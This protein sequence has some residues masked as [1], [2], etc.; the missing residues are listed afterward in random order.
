MPN[1][2]L[3]GL[4]TL[5]AVLINLSLG[6]YI[7][8][9]N[10]RDRLNQSYVFVAAALCIWGFGELV[11]RTTSN[12]GIALQA[13]KF[14]S[15]GYIFLP[16]VF[17]DFVLVLI[18]RK[19][20]TAKPYLLHSVVFLPAF[21][22]LV[23]SQTTNYMIRGVTEEYWGYTAILGPY[24][25]GFSVYLVVVVT[26][27]CYLLFQTYLSNSSNRIKKQAQLILI[28]ALLPFLGGSVTDLVFPIFGFHYFEIAVF[29]TAF[30]GIFFAYAI[31]KHKLMVL[32]SALTAKTV[33]STMANSLV[34]I[35][36]VGRI[37]DVNESMLDLLGYKKKELMGKP[38]GT[39]VKDENAISQAAG[40]KNEVRGF[41]A[42]LL[43]K[44]KSSVPV[45]FNLSVL[46]DEAGETLGTVGVAEDL[47]RISTYLTVVTSLAE[48]VDARDSSTAGHSKR[49]TSCA[50]SFAKGLGLSPDQ[51]KVL[52][53]AARL[54]DIGKV[55]VSDGVL[56]K[57]GPLNEDE[58]QQIRTHPLVAARILKSLPF[59][60]EEMPIIR[61]HHERFD[62]SGY[63]AGL[64]CKEIPLGARI[65]ALA[66]AFDAMMSSRPYRAPLSSSEIFEEL[67]KGRGTQFDP[68]LLD[69]FITWVREHESKY[70]MSKSNGFFQNLEDLAEEQIELLVIKL[71]EGD[72]KEVGDRLIKIFKRIS[73]HLFEELNKLTGY[74]I[75]ETIEKNL[76]DISALSQSAFYL[77]QG[78]LEIRD[79]VSIDLDQLFV[80]YRKHFL[81]L[82]QNTADVIGM[83]LFERILTDSIE[84]EG[85]AVKLLYSEYLVKNKVIPIYKRVS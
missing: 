79:D 24:F 84:K 56:F 31:S 36:S 17:L 50:L 68:Q 33:L 49:V 61:H 6:T 14:A 1:L 74:R 46:R 5:V 63:P 57:L 43:A 67:A 64:R 55:G 53:T 20:I 59:L 19:E 8:Y 23:L 66:D 47:R 28:G 76:N 54:H 30:T 29:L 27:S 78:C 34:V 75:C 38:I 37:T 26:L 11:M 45:T 7:I 81:L 65:L 39:I 62:G 12:P 48:T 83:R 21:F 4:L 40:S 73:L 82:K 44:D 18:G 35:N 42:Q 16:G 22:F 32:D 15:I 77:K 3:Y 9:K 41:Y 52:K 2:S 60:A 72:R 85:E 51:L 71:L 58:W 13:E 70:V 80:E 25:T 10:S 69:L